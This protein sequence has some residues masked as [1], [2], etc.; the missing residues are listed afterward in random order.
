M[1]RLILPTI[2]LTPMAGGLSTSQLVAFVSVAGAFGSLA[3]AHLTASQLRQSIRT[4]RQITERPFGVNLF[5]PGPDLQFSSPQIDFARWALAP[6][7]VEVR[8]L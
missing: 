1:P 2:M 7:K 6:L 5:L 8:D 4:T 3:G